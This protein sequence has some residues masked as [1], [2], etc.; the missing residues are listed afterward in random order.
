MTIGDM[1]IKIFSLK[2]FYL[3]LF[4]SEIAQLTASVARYCILSEYFVDR[5][6]E[7]AAHISVYINCLTT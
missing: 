5:N 4:L 6:I 2:K 3:F 1:E 7:V